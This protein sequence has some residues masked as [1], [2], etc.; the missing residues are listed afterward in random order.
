M[1]NYTTTAIKEAIDPKDV[2]K[3]AEEAKKTIISND[4][5]A[6]I[7]YIDQLNKKLGQLSASLNR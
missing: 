1:I 4:A 7:D 6:V 3:V 2:E 5:Y